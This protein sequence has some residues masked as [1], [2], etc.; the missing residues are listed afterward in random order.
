VPLI[1]FRF[2]SSN[3]YRIVDLPN[4]S[5]GRISEMR[6]LISRVKRTLKA[7]IV[8]LLLSILAEPEI[9]RRIFDIVHGRVELERGL[10]GN[11]RVQLWRNATEQTAAYV[12][13]HMLTAKSCRFR[14]ELFDLGLSRAPE[15]GLYLEFGVESGGSINYLAKRVKGTVHGFDSFEGL[16]E[17]WFDEFDKSAFSTNSKLPKC[18]SNVQLHAGLFNDTLPEFAVTYNDCVAFMHIDCD[19][20]ASTKTVFDMLGDRISSGT[21]IQFDEY[22]NYPGW[23]QHEFKAF[24]EFIL[25]RKLNYQYLGYCRTHYAVSV[26][27]L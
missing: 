23:M 12:E 25:D 3:R 9:E 24:Q 16:P 10:Q 8:G 7:T 4:L 6:K 26:V 14:E 22:F 19:L 18:E 20:Y 21:V 27:I 5:M 13:E 17:A 1:C 2:A 15:D 11:V